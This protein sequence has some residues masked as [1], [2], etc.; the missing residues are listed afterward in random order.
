MLRCGR[1][2]C[3]DVRMVLALWKRDEGAAVVKLMTLDKS[4]LFEN[5]KLA[6]TLRD[7]FGGK[8]HIVIFQ[9][10]LTELRAAVVASCGIL[11]VRTALR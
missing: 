2:E 5:C 11:L 9:D 3:D 7:L 6:A 8:S 4:A 10:K 1:A